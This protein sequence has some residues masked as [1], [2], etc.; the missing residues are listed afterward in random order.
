MATETTKTYEGYAVV[1]R[2]DYYGPSTKHTLLKGASLCPLP[3]FETLAEAEAALPDQSGPTYLGH[4][5]SCVSRDVWG[6]LQ[7]VVPCDTCGWPAQML[8]GLVE[9]LEDTGIDPEDAEAIEN[10]DFDVATAAAQAVGLA[11]VGPDGHGDFWL[12]EPLAD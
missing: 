4:N 10:A 5:E 9:V 11:L 7:S 2:T 12:C 3:I 6:V 1:V 8:T